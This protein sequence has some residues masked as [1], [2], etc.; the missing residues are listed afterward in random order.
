MR[1][2]SAA[3]ERGELLV[4][5]GR[6]E[7]LELRVLLEEMLAR[8]ST[9]LGLEVLVL[10][11]DGFHEGL[12][13]LAGLIRRDQRVP[14]TAPDHLDDVPARAAVGAFEFLDDLAVAAHGAIEPLQIAVDD[15]D[16]VVELLARGDADGAQRLRLVHLAVAAEAPHLARGGVGETAVMQI[17]H[18]PRLVDRLDRS[19]AHRDAGE[20]P[21]VRHQPAVRIAGKARLERFHAKAMHLGFREAAFEE[22]ARVDTRRVVTLDVEEVG[23]VLVVG[24]FPEMVEADVVERRRAL[25]GRDVAADAGVLAVGVHHHR[26]RVPADDRADLPLQSVIAGRARL[27]FDGNGVDVGG[28]CGER[29]MR[30]AAARLLGQRLEQKVRALRALR[31]EHGGEGIQPLLGFGGVGVGHASAGFVRAHAQSHRCGWR[32]M[33]SSLA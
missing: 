24:A 19:Q 32:S 28:I 2:V 33:I 23:A 3:V 12:Q 7:A 17:L 10:A 5:P 27:L 13:E 31:L 20:L 1:V 15:E 6:D 29:N 30:A 4:A 26:H 22:G 21:V 9:A 8:I 16:Q 11:I 18:Q 14:G 25:E